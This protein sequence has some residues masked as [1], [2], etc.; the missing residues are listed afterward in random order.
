MAHNEVALS[1]FYSLVFDHLF[2]DISLTEGFVD[3]LGAR[4]VVGMLLFRGEV[5]SAYFKIVVA[6]SVLENF[7]FCCDFSFDV[8]GVRSC[9]ADLV[10]TGVSGLVGHTVA[11]VLFARSLLVSAH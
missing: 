11:P 1:K 5:L 3:H 6:D 4:F 10:D 8:G 2:V 9:V 7:G